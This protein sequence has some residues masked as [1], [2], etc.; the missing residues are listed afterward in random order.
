MDEFQYI[1]NDNNQTKNEPHIDLS[2]LP[3]NL[4]ISTITIIC[5][6]GTL[7]N[8][9]NIGKY[10]KLSERSILSIKHGAQNDI[11]S[12]IK[13]KKKNKTVNKTKKNFY[14]QATLVVNA[15]DERNINVKLFK[16]GSIQMTGCKSIN[17]FNNTINILCD[18]LKK[19]RVI[20]KS[21]N[22][23]TRIPFVSNPENADLDKIH[24]FKIKLINSNYYVGFLINLIA[25][26]NIMHSKN[27]MSSYEPCIHACVNIKYNYDKNNIIS[28]FVFEKGSIII[29]GAKTQE[30][31]IEAYKFINAILFENFSKIVK[32]D[33]DTFLESDKIK[34]LVKNKI[35]N[36]QSNKGN[37]LL[38]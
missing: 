34:N 32:V 17:D 3:K 27:I 35:S 38:S 5:K 15:K 24:D 25:L 12:I 33:I 19:K 13:C 2:K 16:N 6:L 18:E 37:I 28:I 7:I 14:N 26:Q 21:T 22:K 31:I 36:N 10:M 29:T 20:Y 1:S 4:K 8:I 9:I 23:I 11:R 30:H